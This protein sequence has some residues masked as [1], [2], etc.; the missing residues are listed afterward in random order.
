MNPRRVVV[1]SKNEIIVE[2]FDLPAL[3]PGQVL[4]ETQASAISPGTEMAF[5]QHKPNTTG[6]YP[7]Y[8]G[9]SACSRIIEK[10]ASVESLDVGQRVV[11]RTRHASHA[12]LDAERCQI[13]PDNLTD[14]EAAVHR[15]VSIALQGVRK[16]QMQLGWDV[17]VIGLGP[18]GNLAGQLARAAGATYVEGIDPIGW[19][20]DIALQT[21]YDAVSDSV[22]SVGLS[23]GYNATIEATGVPEV[24]PAAFQLAKMYGRVVLLA[25]TRGVT[26]KVNF[27]QDVHKKGLTVLG[28]H[29][30]NRPEVDD[31]LNFTTHH[32]DVETALKLMAAGRINVAPLITDKVPADDAAKAYEMLTNRNKHFLVVLDWK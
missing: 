16:A 11:Y 18:I 4:L 2:P 1:P 7:F 20:C 6:E 26:E 27:Y 28:A 24:V 10:H 31:Y 25:S 14:E 15:L 8:P 3:G 32:T 30:S 13:V 5:L 22:D 19:R 17:A 12:I 9:Y 29:D 21:G 23:S